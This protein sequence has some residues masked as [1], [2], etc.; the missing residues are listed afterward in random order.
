MYII[1]NVNISPAK[2]PSLIS[3]YDDDRASCQVSS[4]IFSF[5]RTVAVV[6]VDV[7]ASTVANSE[8][9]AIF[10][11]LPVLG[12][13]RMMYDEGF[14]PEI[15]SKMSIVR[16]GGGVDVEEDET[17]WPFQN[18]NSS[19]KTSISSSSRLN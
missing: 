1:V 18:F 16:G 9:C 11:L 13:V 3:A 2:H 19:F 4:N 14:N 17:N 5:R 10:W 7:A 12:L 15:S 6:D 8:S